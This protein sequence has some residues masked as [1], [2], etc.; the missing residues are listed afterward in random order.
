MRKLIF[1]ILGLIMTLAA[2][3]SAPKPAQGQEVCPLCII[4][5]HCCLIHGQ[6]MCLPETTHCP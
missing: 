1:G 2:V 6:A 3:V 5:Y 4:G